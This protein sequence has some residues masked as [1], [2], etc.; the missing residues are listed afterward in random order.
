MDITYSWLD[1]A[2]WN[3]FDLITVIARDAVPTTIF[4]DVDM[5]WAE[6]LRTKH[7]AC[8]LKLTETAIILKAIAIAQSN[9]PA[10][11]SIVM[12]FGRIATFEKICAGITVERFVGAKPAVFFGTIESPEKKSL[13]TI[14]MELR[15]FSKSEI[16]QHSQLALEE[17]F[18]KM[19]WLFRQLVFRLALWFPRFR[20]NTFPATFGVSSLGKFGVKAITGPCVCTS[21]FGVGAVQERPVA[22]QGQVVIHQYLTLSLLFDHRCMDG[23]DAARFMNAVKELL[24][25]GLEEHLEGQRTLAPRISC[26]SRIFPLP[27][28]K[29]YVFQDKVR[30][31]LQNLAA[32]SDLRCKN[33][34]RSKYFRKLKE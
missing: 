16:S 33:K 7:L 24:E 9:Y 10:S 12:P 5:T 27:S 2:R 30:T 28:S 23:A 25:G 19:P 8:G 11:R 13:E 18:S 6:D 26:E 17:K 14:M 34:L 4:C 15:R 20:L 31:P 22:K 32:V 29:I 3:V 1:R 21:T